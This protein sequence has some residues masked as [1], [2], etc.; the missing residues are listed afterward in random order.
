M[1]L[2][3]WV[4]VLLAICMLLGMATLPTLAESEN[5]GGEI[6]PPREEG[7]QADGSEPSRATVVFRFDTTPNGHVDIVSGANYNSSTDEYTA[8]GGSTVT[9][10]A[11]ADE[12]Y[13]YKSGSL[14]VYYR[15]SGIETD[16]PV[17]EETFSFTVPDVRAYVR[18]YAEFEPFTPPPEPHSIGIYYQPGDPSGDTVSVDREA[19]YAGETVTVRLNILPGTALDKLYVMKTNGDS[20]EVGLVQTDES[21]YT[22]TM[23]DYNVIVYP[24]FRVF[25][26]TVTNLKAGVSFSELNY[27]LTVDKTKDLHYGDTVIITTLTYA[28][29]LDLIPVAYYQE[30]GE[31][32]YV[33]LS[34][35]AERV[36]GTAYI[37]EYTFS[38]PAHDVTVDATGDY[39]GYRV[40]SDA[41]GPDGQALPAKEHPHLDGYVNG[42]HI[43]YNK[44]HAAP[45]DTVDFT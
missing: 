12:G 32:V 20:A 3:R 25:S 42:R 17:D 18:L 39:Q 40:Y 24:V 26:Y 35:P 16:V 43:S 34:A 9:L 13:R 11:V 33:A 8:P 29:L 31:T 23:P 30:N 6:A 4:S 41:V 14:R 28:S 21:T 27:E 45:G 5:L 7:M 22:F 36:D 1:K 44:Y 19:A 15:V 2:K 38:M 10:A 37:R